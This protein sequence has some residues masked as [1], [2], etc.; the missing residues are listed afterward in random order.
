MKKREKIIIF[1]GSFDPIHNSHI[2][3]CENS[4]KAIFPDR[5]I[6]VP[7]KNPRWKNPTETIEDRLN[8]IKL[9]LND[10]SLDF[11]I[12]DCEIKSRKDVD[13]TIE[14]IEFLKEKYKNGEFFML[15]GADQVNKFHLWRKAHEIAE[16]V[17]IIYYQRPGYIINENNVSIYKMKE[18]PGTLVDTSSTKIRDLQS[19]DTSLSVINYI[20]DNKLYFMNK[21]TKYLS[22]RR[23]EHSISVANLA[24]KVALNNRLENP[25]NYYLAGLIH[26]LGKN[27]SEDESDELMEKYFKN[28][29]NMPKFAHHQFIGYILAIKEFGITNKEILNAIKFHC[30]GHKDM[31]SLGK[32]IYACDKIEPTRGYDSDYMIDAMM[33][34]YEKGFLLV[35]SENIK[36]INN[37][38]NNEVLTSDPLTEECI[39]AYLN[40][41]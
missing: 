30:T 31:S 22:G 4:I 18:I 35:L 8:M 13:Y 3:L 7:S 33:K 37:K 24:Y 29:E 39:K 27:I 17:Q 1:G 26:D 20:V 14:T 5:L 15:I 10:Y 34:D 6:L 21:I 11:E 28:Y 36:F 25:G 9:I 19:L 32:I 2:L 23:L 38:I 40:K 41:N 12:E 16:E